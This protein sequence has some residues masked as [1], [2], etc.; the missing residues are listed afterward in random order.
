MVSAV[1]SQTSESSALVVVLRSLLY[2]HQRLL[3][4]RRL[5][6]TATLEKNSRHNLGHAAP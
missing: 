2:V 4:V 5:V 1:V 6:G 3:S